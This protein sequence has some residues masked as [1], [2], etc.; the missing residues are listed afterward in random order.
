MVDLFYTRVKERADGKTFNHL[1]QKLTPA[2]QEQVL[3]YRHWED[4]HRSL[5]G[6]ALLLTALESIGQASHTLHDLKFS[7][8]QRPYFDGPTDFNISHSGEFVMC[9]ISKDGPIGIDVE[10]IKEIPLADFT[11]LFSATELKR[12]F[13]DASDYRP[14][15][16][17]WTQKEAYLKAIGLGL[18]VPLREVEVYENKINHN[19]KDWFL[20]EVTLDPGYACHLCTEA[21]DTTFTLRQVDFYKTRF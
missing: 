1:L 11:D 15:Y 16:T 7:E 4:A 12:I 6:K 9:A 20:Q 14:F 2:Q 18:N 21:F 10:E 13:G 3:R 8:F 19:N 17:L 5:F